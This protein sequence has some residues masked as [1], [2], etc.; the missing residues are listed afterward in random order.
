MSL[1][2]KVSP[3]NYLYMHMLNTSVDLVL[4]AIFV[5]FIK[6]VSFRGDQS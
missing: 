4:S 2:S 3:E 6:H 1:H 5:T